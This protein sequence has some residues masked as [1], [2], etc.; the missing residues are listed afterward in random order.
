MLVGATAG[1]CVCRGG[2]EATWRSIL[3]TDFSSVE[4]RSS[5]GD[6]FSWMRLI[7]VGSSRKKSIAGTTIAATAPFTPA[8]KTM[9]HRIAATGEGTRWRSSHSRIGTIATDIT[10]A[11]V[12]GRKNSAP[13][14][15]ANGVPSASPIPAISVSAASSRSR[16]CAILTASSARIPSGKPN[17]PSASTGGAASSA[18]G[19]GSVTGSMLPSFIAHP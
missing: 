6:R 5:S 3:V 10:S 19:V 14:F 15:S 11:I 8:M 7:R 2:A 12:S 17:G 13:A 1:V 4:Y 16:R 9:M 18:G